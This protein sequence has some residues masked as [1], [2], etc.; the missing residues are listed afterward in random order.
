MGTSGEDW[1]DSKNCHTLSISLFSVSFLRYTMNLECLK[2]WKNRETPMTREQ[3]R[4]ETR[5]INLRSAPNKVVWL[6]SC[7]WTVGKC[8]VNYSSI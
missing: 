3:K 1:N 6:M 5:E 7:S 2:L 4:E 8:S